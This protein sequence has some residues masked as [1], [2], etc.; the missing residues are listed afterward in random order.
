MKDLR[1]EPTMPELEP[2]V[3]KFLENR[4]NDY[5][6]LEHFIEAGDY[7]AA[8]K[9][10]HNWKGY[11]EPYGFAHLGVIAVELEKTILLKDKALCRPFLKAI[12]SYLHNKA[13]K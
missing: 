13:F 8:R 12:D 2:F 10:V 9:I 3:G 1:E 7:E 11:C 6:Q 5:K 4:K